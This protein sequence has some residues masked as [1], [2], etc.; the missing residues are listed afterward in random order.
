MSSAGIERDQWHEIGE[1]LLKHNMSLKIFF[2]VVVH[3]LSLLQ[4]RILGLK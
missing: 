2:K 4:T 1:N 3:K